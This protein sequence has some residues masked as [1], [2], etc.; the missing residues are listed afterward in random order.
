M[1]KFGQLVLRKIIE[2]CCHQMSYFKAKMNQIRS[3]LSS[4][5]DPAGELTALPSPLGGFKGPTFNGVRE[6]GGFRKV[7]GVEST[8]VN[9]RG[10]VREERKERAGGAFLANKNLRLHPY[11]Q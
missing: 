1:Q 5:T 9:G 4:A 7:G 11:K 10:E 6:G 3:L 8:D 2:N